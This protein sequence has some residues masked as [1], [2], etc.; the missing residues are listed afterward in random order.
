MSRVQKPSPQT[1]GPNPLS[2]SIPEHHLHK[3]QYQH[4]HLHLQPR[5]EHRRSAVTPLQAPTN[6]RLVLTELLCDS[7]K[8]CALFQLG[9]SFLFLAVFLAL[10]PSAH[11]LYL[12]PIFSVSRVWSPGVGRTRMWRTLM[13]CEALTFPPFSSLSS[14]FA[15]PLPFA[16]LDAGVLSAVLPLGAMAAISGERMDALA[17]GLIYVCEADGG[18]FFVPH[19]LTAFLQARRWYEYQCHHGDKLGRM[20]SCTVSLYISYRR[21]LQ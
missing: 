20:C 4:Q 7:I 1:Q 17:C 8:R 11:I 9:E 5:P 16:P 12:E 19:C 14:G 13:N 2:S 15:P 3:N 18:V 21:F 6:T 10:R